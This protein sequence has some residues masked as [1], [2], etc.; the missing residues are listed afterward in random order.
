MP[1]IKQED[2]DKYEKPLEETIDLLKA[3]GFHPGHLNY[4]ISYLVN[5]CLAEEGMSYSNA[6]KWI[7]ALE[8]AK[9]EITRKKIVPYEDKKCKENGEVFI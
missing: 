1:Y 9:L 7:G 4:V 6:N 2:R 8:C 5:A 3:S